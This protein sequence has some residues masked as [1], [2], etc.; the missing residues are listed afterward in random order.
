MEPLALI[1]GSGVLPRIVCETA[2]SR[3]VPVVAVAFRAESAKILEPFADV[4]VF[5]VGETE[6]IISRFKEAGCKKLCLIGKIEK[7]LVFENIKFD[8]RALK[9]M[10]RLLKKD[11]TSIMLAII[12]ELE[13]EGFET[14]KQTDWL[15]SLMPPAGVLGKIRPSAKMQADFEFGLNL[16]R[17]MADR[18]IGQAIIVKDGVVLAV[19]A[20]EG[21]DSAID[22]GCAL[23]GSGAAMIKTGR[24]NQDLRFDIPSVGPETVRRL[25]KNRAGGLAVE[26]ARVVVID[27][28]EVISICDDAGIAVVAL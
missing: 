2:K 21:T 24:P 5:G 15:P 3:G 6:K 7:K 10:G 17:E 8:F 25:A 11:D 4:K 28:P 19:E 18:E 14:V 26:A 1:A 9:I 23:G 13:A 16:C 22:R 27:M 20:V 12:R